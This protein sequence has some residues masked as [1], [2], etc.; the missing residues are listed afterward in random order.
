MSEV[1]DKFQGVNN[2]I[3]QL[4]SSRGGISAAPS[5]A[6]IKTKFVD[7]SYK[8]NKRSSSNFFQ[9]RIDN[10]RMTRGMTGGYNSKS[11]VTQH[12]EMNKAFTE[13]KQA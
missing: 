13:Y 11:K 2:T 10:D 6:S 12:N 3:D 9:K 4:D 8:D 7:E 1:K 5:H